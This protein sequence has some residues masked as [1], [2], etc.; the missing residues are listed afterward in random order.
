MLLSAAS[1]PTSQFTSKERDAETG[2]DFFE[3]RYYSGAQGRFVSPDPYNIITEAEDRQHLETY[4]K[5]P[6]NWN[7]YAYVWN[8]PLRYVDPHGET[9]YVI[10][11]TVGNEDGDDE[12]KRVAQTLAKKI[13]KSGSFNSK[14]DTVLVKGVSSKDDFINLLKDANKLESQF[15]R[16]GNVSLVSHGGPNDG[17][18]FPQADSA[19]TRQF[20]GGEAELGKLNIGWTLSGEANFYGCNTA[21]NFAQRFANA[22]GVRTWGF[23]N[24]SSFSNTPHYKDKGYLLNFGNN[25]DLY[26]VTRDGRRMVKRDP[27]EPKK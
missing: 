5:Q 27:L 11:Y 4:L 25:W 8:N 19:G 23:D 2:L 26:M 10:A 18:V 17:P 3:A 22:Q 6:Q 12:F 20:L 7:R 13:K 16:V 14:E 15:G 24:Y 21:V 9:V 1:N